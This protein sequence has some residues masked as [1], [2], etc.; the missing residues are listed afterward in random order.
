MSASPSLAE[1][2]LYFID[3]PTALIAVGTLLVLLKWTRLP[4]PLV[5]LV[6]GCV[7]LALHG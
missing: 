7:G 1:F 6:A 5:I 4:E 2:T 3:V